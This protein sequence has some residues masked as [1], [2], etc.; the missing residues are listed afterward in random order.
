MAREALGEPLF[1]HPYCLPLPL[2]ADLSGNLCQSLQKGL[3]CLLPSAEASEGKSKSSALLMD[4][5]MSECGVKREG[6][7]GHEL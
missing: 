4:K 6:G 3:T 5:Q 1:I 7:K 2:P